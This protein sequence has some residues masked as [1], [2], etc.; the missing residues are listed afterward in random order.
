MVTKKQCRCGRIFYIHKSDIL[1]GGG[2]YCSRE[3]YYKYR[4]SSLGQKRSIESRRRMSL[5]QKGHIPWN[6]GLKGAQVSYRKGKTWNEIW[7]EKQ[8][9]KMQENL[10]KKKWKGNWHKN[11]EG[12]LRRMERKPRKEILYHQYI[13][14]KHNKKRVPKGFLIHHKDDN[15]LNNNIKNLQ[16]M[17]FNEHTRLHHLGLLHSKQTKLKMAKSQ[18]RRRKLE[19][20]RRK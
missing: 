20:R 17:K 6:K 13:W 3:C 12:Y 2:K 1:R 16:L 8:A 14:M 19:Q 10:S 4:P 15:I 9:K 7:G 18:I 5:A 11:K